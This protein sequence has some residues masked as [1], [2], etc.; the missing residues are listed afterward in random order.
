[1]YIHLV[2]LTLAGLKLFSLTEFFSILYTGRSRDFQPR[3]GPPKILSSISG[4]DKLSLR[5]GASLRPSFKPSSPHHL[6]KSARSNYSTAEPVRESPIF[7]KPVSLLLNCCVG[8][9]RRGCEIVTV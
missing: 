8:I 2:F 4:G 6:P 7:T 9:G 5:P 1:M 3:Y